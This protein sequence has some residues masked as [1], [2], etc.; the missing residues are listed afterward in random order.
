MHLAGPVLVRDS[1]VSTSKLLPLAFT[2]I[3]SVI[4]GREGGIFRDT[5]TSWLVPAQMG[6]RQVNVAQPGVQPTLPECKCYLQLPPQLSAGRGPLG[7]TKA[8]SGGLGSRKHF[9][10]QTRTKCL[11]SRASLSIGNCCEL[12]LPNMLPVGIQEEG[13]SRA[14]AFSD[15]QSGNRNQFQDAQ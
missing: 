11:W 3:H 15:Q 7:R 14:R 10:Q 1:L 6:T 9:L 2:S 5:A 8:E 12:Q 13:G 4:A